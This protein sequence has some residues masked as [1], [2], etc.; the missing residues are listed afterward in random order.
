MNR[1]HGFAPKYLEGCI[2]DLTLG[3]LPVFYDEKP[4]HHK[5]CPV[6]RHY[7][8]P[9]LSV[10]H[11]EDFGASEKVM[12]LCLE[13]DFIWAWD[14]AN[15]RSF[16]S[17]MGGDGD[18][19]NEEKDAFNELEDS[20]NLLW[21]KQLEIAGKPGNVEDNAIAVLEAMPQKYRDLPRFLKSTR[22]QREAVE[23]M[24]REHA[25][26]VEITKF[27]IEMVTALMPRVYDSDEH[28]AAVLKYLNARLEATSS[29]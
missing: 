23:K 27:Q 22:P 2:Q 8:H 11:R 29:S 10:I 15:I 12:L 5:V 18:E 16:K 6:C 19:Y 3:S 20:R 7:A 17:M 13:S 1:P 25:G 24:V 26:L 9:A 4:L 14:Y 21:A 28:K